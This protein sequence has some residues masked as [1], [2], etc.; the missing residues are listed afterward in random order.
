[1]SDY[2]TPQPL[3]V[4]CDVLFGLGLAFV[5]ICL[6]YYFHPLTNPRNLFFR[7]RTAGEKFL[8]KR[9]VHSMPFHKIVVSINR[10]FPRPKHDGK[11]QSP[12]QQQT[13]YNYEK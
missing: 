9:K 8:Q 1:M 4:G 7:K 5:L 6:G 10:K 11:N 2:A 12:Q 3:A 13:R